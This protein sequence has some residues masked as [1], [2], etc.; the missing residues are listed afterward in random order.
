VQ[1]GWDGCCCCC[2][3]CCCQA[4]LWDTG[5]QGSRVVGPSLPCWC[6]CAVSAVTH[7]MPGPD[8]GLCNWQCRC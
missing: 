6:S 8:T 7:L 5:W 1:V 2:C 3:C 4:G